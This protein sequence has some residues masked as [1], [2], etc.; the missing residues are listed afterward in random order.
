MRSKIKAA[1]WNSIHRKAAPQRWTWTDL[2][3][4]ALVAAGILFLIWPG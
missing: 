3:F 1:I 4:A 2:L